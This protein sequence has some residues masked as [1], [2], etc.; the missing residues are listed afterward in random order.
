MARIACN[1]S[2]MADLIDAL[3]KAEDRMTEVVKEVDTAVAE[4][5]G[6]WS[7]ESRQAF[8]RF[9]REWRNGAYALSAALRKGIGQLQH[10]ADEYRKI[11]Q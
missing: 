4:K 9:Y 8:V 1:L 3:R 10:T 2:D 7:G 6:G 11:P 5:T